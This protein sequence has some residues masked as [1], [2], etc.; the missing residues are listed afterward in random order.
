M[1][2]V[3]FAVCLLLTDV[4]INWTITSRWACRQRGAC[5]HFASCV[6]FQQAAHLFLIHGDPKAGVSGL[7][8]QPLAKSN[9]PS[10]VRY[11]KSPPVCVFMLFLPVARALVR[12]RG[13]SRKNSFAAMV[14]A[15]DW[16]GLH[17]AM[18]IG[19]LAAA[20][21]LKWCKLQLRTRRSIIPHLFKR[22]FKEVHRTPKI[23]IISFYTKNTAYMH[24]RSELPNFSS[25]T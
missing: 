19:E 11:L 13:A 4:A 5:G 22:Q 10:A 8:S 2:T 1:P 6:R 18:S 21:I 7:F 20:Q 23:I 14:P 12:S 17:R 3:P 9:S 16:I 24:R 25:Y 15:F